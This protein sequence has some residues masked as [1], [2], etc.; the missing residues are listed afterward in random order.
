MNGLALYELLFASLDLPERIKSEQLE[1][2]LRQNNIRPEDLTLD[3]LR[4]IVAD[5]LHR[6]ILESEDSHSEIQQ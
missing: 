1:V 4:E 6:L 2:L 5:L 3:T